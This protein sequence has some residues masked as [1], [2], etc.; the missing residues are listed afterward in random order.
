MGIASSGKP[1]NLPPRLPASIW[2][3]GQHMKLVPPLLLPFLTIHLAAGLKP[4]A[5]DYPVIPAK[6][7]PP[8]MVYVPGGEFYRGT[9]PLPPA[10]HDSLPI[11]LISVN[12]FFMDATEVTNAQFAKFVKET[13]YVTI[14]EIKPKPEDFPEEQR[15]FLK[16]ELLVPGS[17]V[18]TPAK[19][20][21]QKWVPGSHLQWWRYEPGANWR[22]P[23][24][25]DSNIEGKDDHPVVHVAWK[26]AMAYCKWAGKRLPTEAEWECAARGGLA[27]QLHI[28]GPEKTPGGV[29]Q[30]NTF[31]G[32]FPV[33]NN[34]EDGWNL[35]CPVKSYPPNPY[36]LYEMSGNVWEWCLDWY[37]PDYYAVAPDKNPLG[38]EDS[39][40]PLEQG[41]PKRVSR[42][43]SFLCS[44]EYCI[45]YR[46]GNRGRS[47]P[48]TGL[49]HTGFRCVRP[50]GK[51]TVPVEK[52]GI[53]GK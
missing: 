38:P 41:V 49:N 7:V 1:E 50:V 16:P 26:D 33:S 15:E 18:F 20:E 37:R 19:G 48:M 29:H 21:V 40:D 43:G 42:G 53:P 47:D 3:K 4:V 31:Q 51:D 44:D 11:R 32:S 10:E 24:G 9:K 14:A 25:A 12:P 45:N 13:G 39:F 36:G 35:S 27:G 46:V 28:W 23:Y 52:G 34:K 8:G 5:P 22:H 17:V 30:A 2:T 6:R